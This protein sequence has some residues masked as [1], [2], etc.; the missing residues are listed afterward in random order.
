MAGG[1]LT[2]NILLQVEELFKS[3]NWPI[4]NNDTQ[5]GL[6]QRFCQRL[7][8]FDL[9][10][11]LLMIKLSTSFEKVLIE[12]Y[13]D[14][15]WS[16]YY[17]VPQA[18]LENASK[19]IFM[20][21][22]EIGPKKDEVRTKSSSALHYI[23]RNGD[24][25][26]VDFNNKF[27]F[28]EDVND[29]IKEFDNKSI[30]FLIDDFLGS[31]Q[32]AENAINLFIKKKPE[33][34]STNIIVLTMVAQKQGISWIK[35]NTGCSTF[36]NRVFGKGISDSFVKEDIKPSI[37]LMKKME[38]K[39]APQIQKN[40]W[41]LGY[42]ECEALISISSKSPNNTFPVFWFETEAKVSPFPRYKKFKRKLQ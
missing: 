16:A 1:N 8:V 36:A 33:L 18:V 23:L 17:S 11:Q 28:I 26:W 41:S 42:A 13:T 22:L 27:L 15:F 32:T 37:A 10:G 30:L 20:P 7:S 2:L 6:Y 24:Y 14:Y 29:L 9:D 39:L 12:Q 25:D 31:G 35:E 3:K 19:L 5:F 4:D 34:N 21:L 38:I 40:G